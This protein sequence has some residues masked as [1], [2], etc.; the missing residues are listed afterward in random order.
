MKIIKTT[1]YFNLTTEELAHIKPGNME[2]G[3]TKEDNLILDDGVII[4]WYDK[5]EN[6]KE[7]IKDIDTNRFEVKAILETIKNQYVLI[8][9]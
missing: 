1:D 8:L 9:V 2:C 5:L 3:Y 4:R 7:C 6:L